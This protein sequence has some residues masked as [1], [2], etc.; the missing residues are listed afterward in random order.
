MEER[1][2]VDPK[3]LNELF[4][5]DPDDYTQEDITQIVATFRR[6]RTVWIKEKEKVKGTKKS[7]N[8]KK[9]KETQAGTLTLE[10][11]GF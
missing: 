5:K 8:T 11:L 9:L 1:E 4:S 7:A 3:A 10:D 2:K 6:M